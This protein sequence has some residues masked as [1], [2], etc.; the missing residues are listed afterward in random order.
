MTDTF[1]GWLRRLYLGQGRRLA[2]G[3]RRYLNQAGLARR[4]A[5]VAGP[6]NVTVI[7]VAGRDKNFLS[8][9]FEQLL[10]LPA[11]TLARAG[12][13]NSPSSM[14]VAEADTGRRPH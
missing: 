9:V 6:E 2:R 3:T 5:A 1:D 4:W 11:P 7:V 10:D 14:T 12:T 13:G 8:D